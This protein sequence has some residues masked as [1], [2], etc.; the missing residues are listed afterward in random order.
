MRDLWIKAEEPVAFKD[1]PAGDVHCPEA[2]VWTQREKGTS[3]CESRL[4][5]VKTVSPVEKTRF[6]AA[7]IVFPVGKII[8]QPGN[9]FRSREK[10]FA[11]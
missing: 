3:G 1:S 2:L 6:L 11:G 8:S 10:P 5:V 9:D 7:K 4:L